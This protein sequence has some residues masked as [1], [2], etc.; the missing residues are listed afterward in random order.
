MIRRKDDSMKNSMTRSTFAAGIAAAAVAPSLAMPLPA[1][2]ATIFRY[3]HG[4]HLPVEH[5]VHTHLVQMWKAV[6]VATK[7]QLVVTVYPNQQL[8][9]AT[10]MFSQLRT[11][12]IQFFTA[13]GGTLSQVV[14]I[15]SIEN[16][17]YAYRTRDQAFKSFE[18]PLGALVRKELAA[19]KIETMFRLWDDGFRQVTTGLKPI[20][21]A[22]DMDGLKL[23]V[24]AGPMWIDLFK[25]LGAAPTT[26]GLGDLYV[27]L[28]THLID[29]E[30]ST[31][32]DIQA[33]RAY[34]VQKY[35]S[36]TNHMYTAF[37]LAANADAFNAL[38][39]A[40]Q[41]IVRKN[42]DTFALSERREIGFRDKAVMDSL[43]RSGLKIGTTN[44][45]SFR[46]K[47]APYYGRW[48]QTFGAT[49]WALLEA[50]TG[51]LV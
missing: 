7:G 45:D 11:G 49:A 18:G 8:G 43:Q 25:A 30:E 9:N 51:K 28:Q 38:P 44:F 33:S 37:F 48:K 31:L 39:S 50:D 23:R 6:E 35:L 29:G 41:A 1:R 2:G 46:K 5:P 13:S 27:S 10:S 47:L 14:P 3:K 20:A 24:A 26:I 40:V 16:V 36:L 42:N 21:N 15:A 34:E 32:L 12:A 4:H 19:Q 22:D 17:G